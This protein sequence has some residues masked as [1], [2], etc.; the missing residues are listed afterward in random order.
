[1]DFSCANAALLSPVANTM[2]A[3]SRKCRFNIFSLPLVISDYKV[4]ADEGRGLGRSRRCKKYFR[5]RLLDHSYL[6]EK[7]DVARAPSRLSEIVRRHD[8]LYAGRRLSAQALLDRL[9]RCRTEVCRRFV[10]KQ[11]LRI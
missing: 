10:E 11:N 5:R 2:V 3:A 8:D 7:H 4:A 9:G 1:M 6:H